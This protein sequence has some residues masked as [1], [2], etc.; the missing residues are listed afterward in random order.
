MPSND[1]EKIYSNEYADFFI[2]YYGILGI[3]EEIEDSG[4]QVINFFLAVAYLPVSI[5]TE[6]VLTKTGYSVPALFGMTNVSTIEASGIKRLRNIPNFDFRGK[7]V[8]IGIVDSGIDYTNPIFQNADQTSRVAAI[9]DQTIR[10]ERDQAGI[11]YG[12][13]Y[14]REQINEALRNKDPF[15]I[16]PTRDEIGHGTMIAGIAAGNEVPEQGFYGVAPEADIIVVKMKYAKP[17][18]RTYFQVPEDVVC[19]QENDLL[20]GVQYLL[21]YSRRVNQPIVICMSCDTSQYARDGK[22]IISSWLSLQS[23]Y[24]GLSVFIPAGN[25][26]NARRHFYGVIEKAKGYDTVELNVGPGEQ[27][28]TMELW[29]TSPNT[30]TID[31]VSPSGEYIPKVNVRLKETL[32]ISFIFEATTIFIQYQIIDSQNGD[33]LFRFRFTKPSEGIWKFNVYGRGV[34][35][36]N[37][38]I[39]L[40]MNNFVAS[41]TYFIRSDPATTLLSLSCAIIP[42]TVTA[43]NTEDDSLYSNAG[44]GYTRI[45][46]IKPDIAAPGVDIL[47]PNLEHGFV[48]ITGTSAAAAHAAGVAAMLFEWGIIKGNY[49][50]MSTQDIKI[51]MIRGAR[52][53]TDLSYPNKDWG[54][55]ILDAYSVFDRIR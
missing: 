33:Q 43:Y 44:K 42:V 32:S 50:Y 18:L 34:Y 51:F 14:S 26:G 10:S 30:F 48:R 55:G 15:Q 20:F 46:M 41:D 19:Y 8:L 12:T 17:Y 54:Y 53:N 27:G 39:W 25:E 47:S 4:I 21:N 40:P 6:D 7:G 9:W 22:D 52:R 45:D 36:M 11:A 35:P 31:I 2:E 1:I 28:F 37:F 38:H 29:G 16:V 24:P 3:L 49:P 13:E 23:G 5:M